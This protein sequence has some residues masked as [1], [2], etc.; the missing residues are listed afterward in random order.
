MPKPVLITFNSSFP[1]PT[2]RALLN[3]Y[4]YSAIF[5]TYTTVSLK[6]YG[7][8][9]LET[10]NYQ[11]SKRLSVRVQAQKLYLKPLITKIV[12]QPTTI[13]NNT[14]Y[15]PIGS[16]IAMTSNQ[17]ELLTKPMTG[18][19]RITCTNVD[20][21]SFTNKTGSIAYAASS[22]VIYA[23]IVDACPNLREK[24]AISEGT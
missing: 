2:I 10:N 11:V 24:I 18:S 5:G 21:T 12:A 14:V 17:Y 16:L 22:A 4:I 19:F 6:Y 9:G 7:A 1:A 8:D 15:A 23:A 20:G 3:N 13:N